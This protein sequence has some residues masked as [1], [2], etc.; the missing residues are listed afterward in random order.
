MPGHSRGGAVRTAG[1]PLTICR[2]T[3]ACVHGDKLM[4]TGT[5][6]RLGSTCWAAAIACSLP[7]LAQAATWTPL[8]Q[9][10]P[11]SVETMLLLTDG[12]VLAHSYDDPGNI[13]MKLTPAAN[14]SYINGTW[15]T[16]T[17]MGTNRL[18]FASHVMPNGKL[19]VLGG[20]YSGP[21][22]QANWTNT[23]EIYDPLANAWTPIAHHPESQYGDVPSM[24]LD[25]GKILAGSL[26][27]P[28]SYLYDIASN[29]WAKSGTKLYNDSS[30]EETYVKLPGGGVMSY[31]LFKSI[32]TNG[33]YAVVYDPATGTWSGRSPSDG[34]A[35]GSIPQLSSAAMG[36]ELGGAVTLRS[37]DR[38]GQVFFVGATGHTATYSVGTNTW[39]PGPDIIGT[40]NGQS[41]LFGADD[42]PSA[43]LPN[44][45]VMLAADPSPTIGSPFNGPTQLFDYNPDKGTIK[46]VKP[47]LP[48]ALNDPS[49]VYRMLI[50][51]T[52]ELL[53][54][55][56]NSTGW[57]YA[58]PDT[59]PDKARPLVTAVRYNGDG[60]FTMKGKRLNGYSA[61][62]SYGDDAESDENYPIVRFVDQGSGNT[63][64]ARTT[65]WTTTGV[66]VPKAMRTDF[67][68]KAGTPAGTLAVVVSGAGIQSLPL[69]V[70]L[71]AGQVAG[72]GP[73][74]DVP[75]TDCPAAR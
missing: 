8:S 42:G 30:D 50:L 22:M 7:W 41:A 59:T 25:K 9:A 29:T 68:L 47:A 12:T 40:Y 20:E 17:G 16:V 37:K 5:M 39:T 64:Y 62:S 13:W 6:R 19:W 3:H 55:S 1:Q 51:P 63:W 36:Y 66:Q 24:L 58:T 44:G 26:T 52:G 18:Y 48:V 23:G 65:N 43:V 73:A 57:V 46:P 21:N 4:K 28:S 56:G 70:T 33:A 49:Y 75:V 15:S 32:A 27:G 61:G 67:T 71:T 69:C 45:H 10:A 14:G 60:S 38:S 2:T 53:L 74:A 34:T 11:H 31:A 54:S 72:T 35:Q